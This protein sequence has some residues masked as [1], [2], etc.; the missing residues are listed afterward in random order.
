VVLRP[1]EGWV[2]VP[3]GDAA[4]TR[5]IKAAACTWSVQLK[6]GRKVFSQGVWAPQEVVEAVRQ[7]LAGERST[8]QYARKRQADAERR[9]REQ[10]IYVE[11]FQRAVLRFL[12]FDPRYVD[13][14]HQLARAVACAA[15]PV[16]SGT[17]ARTQWISIDRR[18]EAAVLAWMRHHTT[19]Y[20][21]MAIPRQKGRRRQVRR[22]LAQHSRALLNAYRQGKPIADCCLLQAALSCPQPLDITQEPHPDEHRHQTPPPDSGAAGLSCLDRS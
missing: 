17:V 8:P 3:P 18:A 16:G 5:R 7:A 14:A 21:G 1:P 15:T 9:Q 10:N 4:L 19:A 12:A 13:L 20:D 6:K 11:D 22:Q 2:L